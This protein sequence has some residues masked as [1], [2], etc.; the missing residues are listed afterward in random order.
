M[1]ILGWSVSIHNAKY[2]KSEWYNYIK[3][4]RLTLDQNPPVYKW[5]IWVA[6]K[7]I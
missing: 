1:K 6:G 5:L 7:T 3:P 2:L 4:R